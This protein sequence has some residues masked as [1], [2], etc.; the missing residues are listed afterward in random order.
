MLRS[1]SLFLQVMLCFFSPYRLAGSCL[2]EGFR[3]FC[4]LLKNIHNFWRPGG[5]LFLSF[6]FLRFGLKN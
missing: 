5:L 4:F 2:K 1:K 6:F 3:L